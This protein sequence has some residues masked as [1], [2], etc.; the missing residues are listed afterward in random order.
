MVEFAASTYERAHFNAFD[1]CRKRTSRTRK[2]RA[3]S[4]ASLLTG[5][6]AGLE[7]CDQPCDTRSGSG[8][9]TSF[10]HERRQDDA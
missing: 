6:R 3:R 7:C 4:G 5:R 8:R 10:R 1:A 9:G 2:C